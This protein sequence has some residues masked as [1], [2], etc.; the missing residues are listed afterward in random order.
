MPPSTLSRRVPPHAAYAGGRAGSARIAT[1]GAVLIQAWDPN[2][3]NTQDVQGRVTLAGKPVSGVAVRIDGWVAPLT[4]KTGTFTYPADN[5]M[6]GRHV[7]TIASAAGATVDG[8]KL[9]PA[10]QS[11]VMAAKGGISVGYS[12][13][14]S[15]GARPVPREPSCSRAGSRTGRASRPVRSSSTAT[16]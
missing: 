12:I 14:R 11:Q 8:R 15:L 5:T 6:P 2:T 4:D 13:T 9:S 10:E 7:V 3:S 1:P 16:S